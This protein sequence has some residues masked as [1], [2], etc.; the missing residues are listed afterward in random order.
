MMKQKNLIAVLLAG[1][2]GKRFWPISTGKSIIRFFGKPI[3][4]HIL[5]SLRI[6][7]VTN[8]IIVTNPEDA[9]VVHSWEIPG[10]TLETVVQERPTGMADA[11]L[12]AKD[13][14][15]SRPCLVMNAGDVADDVLYEGL[16]KEADEH[17]AL[18]VGKRVTSHFSGGYLTVKNDRLVNIIEKPE[19][20]QEPSDLVNLVFHYFPDPKNF[21]KTLESTQSKNDDVYEKALASYAVDHTVRVIAYNGP[22]QPIKYPWH[23]LNVMD[24]FMGRLELHKGKDVVIKENVV[25]EGAVYIEDG[26]KIFENSKI[27]GPCYIGK[28]T[29]IGN[30]CIIRQS[31]IGAD[32]VV[33]FNCDVTRS[34]VGDNCWFHSNYIGDSVLEENISMGSGAVLANL[35]LD[36]GEI[37]STGRNKLGAMIGKGVRIGVNASIMPGIKIGSYSFIGAGV[38]LDRDLP[39]HSF[40]ASKPGYTIRKNQKIVSAFREAFKKKL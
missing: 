30:N 23:I 28:N 29:I 10:M 40:C 11:L 9:L 22:W 16:L 18:V 1:G 13:V 34:Y 6:F 37:S 17:D 25:I 36:D 19:P 21:F 24:L 35:R 3:V 7:D 14:I 8:A 4:E 5:E 32:C 27:L 12:A 38:V 39:E 31:H 20:G 15:G 26:V 2:E 33:G